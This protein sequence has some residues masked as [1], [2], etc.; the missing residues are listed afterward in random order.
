MRNK[1]NCSGAAL[2][3]QVAQLQALHLICHATP[4][5]QSAPPH[6]FTSKAFGRQLSGAL[7][8][9]ARA[10]RFIRC[11]TTAPAGSEVAHLAPRCY[12]TPGIS[13]QTRHK[14]LSE[15]V[16]KISPTEI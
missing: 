12:C 6:F 14:L 9:T 10:T 16:H 4:K 1:R 7:A 13:V 3:R 8:G 2:L 15:V 5:S 11:S